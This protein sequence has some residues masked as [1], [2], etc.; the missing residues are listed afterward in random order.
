MGEG[1]LPVPTS[2]ILT[3]WKGLELRGG[4]FYKS[5]NLIREGSTLLMT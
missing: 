3:W 1:P 4:L 2:C 5:T